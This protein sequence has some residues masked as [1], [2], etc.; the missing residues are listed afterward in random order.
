MDDR[1]RLDKLMKYAKSLGIYI[2]Q[3]QVNYPN[4]HQVSEDRMMRRLSLQA[5]LG[6][7]PSNKKLSDII[8]IGN[9]EKQKE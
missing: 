3:W 7:I 5:I 8:H 6:P 2:D 4:I 1:E 9:C